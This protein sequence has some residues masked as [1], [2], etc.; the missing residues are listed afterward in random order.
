MGAITICS[1][2]ALVLLLLSLVVVIH[3]VRLGTVNQFESFAMLGGAFWA[4]G[5]L[6]GFAPDWKLC[7]SI[8]EMA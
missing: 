5:N 7:E 8:L 3:R 2:N 6:V 4:T 1:N